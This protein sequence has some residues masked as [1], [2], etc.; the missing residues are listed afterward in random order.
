MLLAFCSLL[1]PCRAEEAHATTMKEPKL[2]IGTSTE[3]SIDP[4]LGESFRFI[5]IENEGFKIEYDRFNNREGYQ[6]IFMNPHTFTLVESKDFICKIAPGVIVG[7]N[8]HGSNDWLLGADASF[9]FPDA[10]IQILQRS[11][12][13]NHYDEHHVFSAFQPLK[14][15]DQ[16]LLVHFLNMTDQFP[17]TSYL[18]PAANVLD[19]DLFFWVGVSPTHSATWATILQATIKF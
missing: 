2:K 6:R 18:G 7:T 1:L 9:S 16:L 11:Y 14:E 10:R 13:G 17:S 8:L 3:F 5:E 19:G 4:L 15:E 12:L